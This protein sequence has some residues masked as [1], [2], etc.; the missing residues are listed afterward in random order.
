MKRCLAVCVLILSNAVFAQETKSADPAAA[1]AAQPAA[2]QK[3]AETQSTEVK[4]LE[5]VDKKKDEKAAKSSDSNGGVTYSA[6]GISRVTSDFDNLGAAVNLTAVQGIKVPT[7]DW[8][9][10]EIDI[11]VTI[12]PGKNDGRT[13]SSGGTTGGGGLPIIGGGG[14]GGGSAPSGNFTRSTSDMRL[15][16]IGAFVVGKTPPEWLYDFYGKA[17]FGYGYVQAG[18]LNGGIEELNGSGTA[19]GIGGGWMYGPRGGVEL[20]YMRYPNDLSYLGFSV[21]Y[22][23]GGDDLSD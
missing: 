12:I 19:F 4:T 9:A 8:I 2:E 14:G 16:S 21:S 22:G 15:L 17:K 23:F 11:G 1:P 18:D 3:P 7:I 13:T 6:I 10:A 5:P 20:M